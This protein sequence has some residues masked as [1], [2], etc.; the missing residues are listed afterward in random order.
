[1]RS[2]LVSAALIPAILLSACAATGETAAPMA[3]ADA[4][5]ERL[6]FARATPEELQVR[7][8]T[9]GCTDADSFR[10]EAA[11]QQGAA[12]AYVVSIRRVERDEC[13]GYKPDG[14]RLEFSRADA[15]IPAGATVTFA[16]P[17]SRG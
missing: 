9:N 16:N 12:N 5:L 2:L 6:L 10:V 7:V 1:M 14:V 4:S 15:G 8:S 3:A 11:P 13:R 17:V